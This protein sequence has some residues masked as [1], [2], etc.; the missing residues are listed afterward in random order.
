MA[1]YTLTDDNGNTQRIKAASITQARI[2]LAEI[3]KS[4]TKQPD[5]GAQLAKSWMTAG[6]HFECVEGGR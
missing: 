2:A 6:A 1:T 4:N 3:N 5:G